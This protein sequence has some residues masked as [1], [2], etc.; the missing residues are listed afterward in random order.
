MGRTLFLHQGLPPEAVGGAVRA[1]PARLRDD[2]TTD[3][4]APVIHSAVCAWCAWP[5]GRLVC[6]RSERWRAARGTGEH[7]LHGSGPPLESFPA[8]RSNPAFIAPPHRVAAW[9]PQRRASARARGRGRAGGG[10]GGR[11]GVPAGR[12]GRRSPVSS[13]APGRLRL[14]VRASRTGRTRG[15]AGVGGVL[16]GQAR[17]FASS[18]RFGG[19]ASSALCASHSRQ[20]VQSHVRSCGNGSCSTRSRTRRRAASGRSFPGSGRTRPG[21]SRAERDRL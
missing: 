20:R 17:S 19:A 2:S 15:G 12:A 5:N 1:A 3:R 7:P 14:G 9:L 4:V 13:R 10:R 6:C 21:W 8:G 16:R 11:R 18:D